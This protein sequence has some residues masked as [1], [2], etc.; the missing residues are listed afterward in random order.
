MVKR[1]GKA[2]HVCNVA[3]KT[4]EANKK[5]SLGEQTIVHP[6]LALH[7]ISSMFDVN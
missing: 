2:N 4:F 1:W 3:E 7:K 5:K 6:H